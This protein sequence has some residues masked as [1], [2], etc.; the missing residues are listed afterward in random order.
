LVNKFSKSSNL[1][2][3]KAYASGV[4]STING[5][6]EFIFSKKPGKSRILSINAK[7]SLI[8]A[9]RFSPI[10]LEESREYGYTRVDESQAFTLRGDDIFIANLGIS[11]RVNKRKISQE[12]KLDIQNITNNSGMVDQ[13]YNSATDEIEYVYQ[14]GLLPNIMYTIEF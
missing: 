10:D 4:I 7:I 5:G 1:L 13:Y 9:R 12:I 11:Y 14:L 2:S 6:K 3:N 8:G